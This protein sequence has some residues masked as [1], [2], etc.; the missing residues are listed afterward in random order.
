M[1]RRK[2]PSLFLFGL[3]WVAQLPLRGDIILFAHDFS[4]PEAAALTQHSPDGQSGSAA[5]LDYLITAR[6]SGEGFGTEEVRREATGLVLDSEHAKFLSVSPALNFSQA[7]GDA[8][9]VRIEISPGAPSPNHSR[10]HWAQLHIGGDKPN[11]FVWAQGWGIL[12]RPDAS[13][14]DGYQIFHNGDSV[15]SGAVPASESYRFDIVVEDGEIAFT[16]NG[17]L[18]SPFGDGSAKYPVGHLRLNHITLGAHNPT[19]SPMLSVFS[20]LS[21][22]RLDLES[23]S[24]LILSSIWPR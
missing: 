20:N 2:L 14:K 4:A 3:V 7:G 12:I 9:R 19:G 13:A 23:G 22:S 5:P 17:E 15:G 10:D 21:V 8:F 11:R 6:G 24:L 18:Q 1:K 16:I